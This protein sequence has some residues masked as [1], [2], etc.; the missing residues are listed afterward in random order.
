MN[1]KNQVALKDE[2]T[3]I[4]DVPAH[5][6]IEGGVQACPTSKVLVWQPGSASSTIF[7]NLTSC[8]D[9]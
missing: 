9:L 6:A 7:S 1:A 5:K 8:M 2:V 3:V 4:L